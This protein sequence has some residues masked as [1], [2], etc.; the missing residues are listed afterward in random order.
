MNARQERTRRWFIV[1]FDVEGD[2]TL[3]RD[4]TFRLGDV[5]IDLC[6]ATNV[7]VYSILDPGEV[8]PCPTCNQPLPGL[9]AV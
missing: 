6:D 5:P 7:Q 2:G 8:K 1:A 4:F 9:E 3:P